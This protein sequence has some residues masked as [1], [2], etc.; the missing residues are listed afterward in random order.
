MLNSGNNIINNLKILVIRL[1]SI[2][3]IILTTGI[4]AYIYDKFPNSEIFYLTD[5]NFS[6]LL[7][8]NPKI[9]KVIKYDKSLN[10]SDQ[11]NFKIEIMNELGFE[12]FDMII[13][14]HNNLR[15][16]QFRKGLSDKIYKINK[17]RLKK[18][19][20]V[21]FKPFYNLIYRDNEKNYHTF[22]N[23]FE[24]VSKVDNVIKNHS[25][26]DFQNE[27]QHYKKTEIFTNIKLE[28]QNIIK[29]INNSIII[30]PGAK[31]Y[32]K[33]YPINKLTELCLM[34]NAK[35]PE[36]NLIL[37]GGKDEIE[38][39]EELVDKLTMKSER[40]FDLISNF[41]GKMSLLETYNIIEHSKLIITNDTGLMHLASATKTPIIALFGSTTQNLGF[42]PLSNNFKII[43]VDL[44]CRPCTHIGRDKC[45]KGHFNCMNLIDNS[46]I[47]NSIEKRRIN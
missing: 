34:I 17:N 4:I 8:F 29:L 21:H 19:S 13:D 35:Y 12:K 37:V 40:F 14:L 26:L 27:I 33:R 11:H 5:K 3:D 22:D 47:I 25:D 18:L 43:E 15:T 23:Y 7:E 9:K 31:H 6:E 45:P 16:K 39:G 38:I 42:T 46:V 30:A 10:Q 28:N 2:G 41:I 44:E 24:V 36:I 32:T 1:S 20:L